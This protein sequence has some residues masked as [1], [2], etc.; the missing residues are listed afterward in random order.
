MLITYLKPVHFL[1]VFCGLGVYSFEF[2]VSGWGWGFYISSLWLQ[3]HV[4]T[5]I[6]LPPASC[7]LPTTS[8]PLSTVSRFLHSA[9]CQLPTASLLRVSV[10]KTIR[11]FISWNTFFT[12]YLFFFSF[13]VTKHLRS[14]PNKNKIS[15]LKYTAIVQP[16]LKRCCKHISIRWNIKPVCMC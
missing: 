12:S 3:I 5:S 10:L 1:F 13:P 14:S 7:F 2:D 16:L 9:F 6:F 8:C 4:R 11:T 15:V